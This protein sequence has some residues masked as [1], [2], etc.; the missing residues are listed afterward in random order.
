MKLSVLLV[1]SL[2]VVGGSA[3]FALGPRILVYPAAWAVVAAIFL[4]WNTV[5]GSSTAESTTEKPM[6]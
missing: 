4:A 6:S 2:L 5:L 3:V 1:G